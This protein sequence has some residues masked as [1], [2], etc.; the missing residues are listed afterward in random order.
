[1]L[2]MADIDPVIHREFSSR[3]E[4]H[5]FHLINRG[6]WIRSTK[7]PIR[8]FFA[9][10]A[11]KG[12]QY[13]PSWGISSGL[14]PRIKGGK[15]YR[16]SSDKN[17]V[18][19]LIIDPV[20]ITGQVPPEAFRHIPNWDTV[21]PEKQIVLC[22]DRF[23]PEA[24]AHFDRVTSIRD[25]CEFFIER[26]RLEYRRFQFHNYDRHLFVHGFVQILNGRVDEGTRAVR[27]RCAELEIEFNDPV[28][29][30]A[31]QLAEEIGQ[32]RQS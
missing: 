13:S 2:R 9:I 26:S 27:Q 8:E 22:A 17:S 6:K 16:Q 10:G 28:L 12:G 30:E 11:L 15:F 32:K 31:L 18:E 3:L 24:L 25:F 14:V 1:M 19:D 5:G 23:V 29:T 7:L 4:P 20:D 21:I